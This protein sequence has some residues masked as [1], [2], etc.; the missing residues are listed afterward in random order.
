MAMVMTGR[1]VT[2]FDNWFVVISGDDNGDQSGGDDGDGDDDY[3][4]EYT[5]FGMSVFAL[6]SNKRCEGW[7][8]RARARG[9]G[10]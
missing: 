3:C 5:L 8:S 4:D 2:V 10:V 1:V 6:P 9:G 7:K